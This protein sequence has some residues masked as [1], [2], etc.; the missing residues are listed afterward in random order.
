MKPSES[1]R[2]G[3][4]L[5][6]GKTD[7]SRSLYQREELTLPEVFIRGK[8]SSAQRRLGSLYQ[9]EKL[10]L[11]EAFISAKYVSAG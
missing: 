2:Y 10:T 1:L 7:S 5:Q 3:K 11:W 9:R 4:F 6:A 8:F